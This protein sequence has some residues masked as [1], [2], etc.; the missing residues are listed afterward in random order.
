MLVWTTN[1]AACPMCGTRLRVRSIGGGFALG[2]DTD[3]LV[4]MPGR[5]VIQA[6]I[7]TCSAC[8]F[9]GYASDFLELQVSEPMV[10]RYFREFAEKL[11]ATGDGRGRASGAPLPH[12]QYYWSALVAPLLGLPPKETGFRMLRAYWCLRLSPSS[13]LP[14]KE[15]DGLGKLY[16]RRAI[17]YLRKALRH[18]QDSALVYL[19]GELCRRN[20]SFVRAQHYFDRFLGSSACGVRSEKSLEYL[21]RAARKLLEAVERQDAAD[22]SMEEILYP[23]ADEPERGRPAR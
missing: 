13:R 15:R 6:E 17:A 1:E 7:H 8:R 22:K 10:E 18:E 4:R 2:Q 5:H 20:G 16:L 14:A 3:L 19:I 23:A 12:L 11:Y 21:R 9:S